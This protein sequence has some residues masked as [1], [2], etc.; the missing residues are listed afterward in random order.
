MLD[1]VAVAEGFRPIE[2][3]KR[4]YCDV[5]MQLWDGTFVTGWMMLSEYGRRTCWSRRSG[6]ITAVYPIAWRPLA[7]GQRQAA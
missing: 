7:R 2:T 5:E 4:D 1:S 6:G 3:L